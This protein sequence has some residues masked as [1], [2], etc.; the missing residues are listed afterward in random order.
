MGIVKKIVLW[1]SGVVQIPRN[2]IYC[3]WIGIRFD[4]TWRFYGLPHIMVCGRGSRISIGRYFSANSSWRHNAYGIIQPVVIR[5]LAHGAHVSIGDHVGISGCT[6]AAKK[7]ITLG[8]H[9]L[10]GSGAV[11]V[12]DDAH[13]IDPFE[14]RADCGGIAK[15]I[16]I[17]DDVFIGARAI[18]LKGVHIGVGSVVGAGAVVTKDVP[19]YSIVA[20]N[21][22]RI[23][24]DSRRK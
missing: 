18:I 7:S 6:I 8:D 2:F 15:P 4:V 21:P 12:D 3:L 11:I 9:V 10:I 16:T 20:G 17:G 5:T 14:R 19:P 1:L 23:I 22:A 13:P 24:G